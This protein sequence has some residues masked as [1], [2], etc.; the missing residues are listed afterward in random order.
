[1]TG[2]RLVQVNVSEGGVPKLPVAAAR[3]TVAG[4]EGDRQRE[5]T[6]HG[7]PHR[8]V[9]LLGI[10]VSLNLSPTLWVVARWAISMRRVFTTHPI[11]MSTCGSE[12]I[13]YAS[14][15]DVTSFA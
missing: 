12:A 7:G 2:G 3:I 14:V 9:S 4:V 11:Q 6:V 13:N 15:M 10:A 1:M 5:V 8:A